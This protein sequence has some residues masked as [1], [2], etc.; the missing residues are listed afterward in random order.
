MEW[1]R[2]AFLLAL[3][4]ALW[5]C[6]GGSGSGFTSTDAG[7]GPTD[8]TSD[9]HRLIEAELVRHGPERRVPQPAEHIHLGQGVRPGRAEPA[10]SRGRLRPEVP[11]HTLAQRG[12]DGSRRMLVRRALSE[13][14]HRE[15]GHGAG[16]ELHSSRR[17]CGERGA[18]RPADRK[19][20]APRARQRGPVR[21]QPSAGH[22]VDPSADGH[23]GG[24]ERQ[25]PGHRGLHRERR[26]T[27]V[28]H[29]AHRP[30]A[31]RVRGGL[32]DGG[33]R[34]HLLGGPCAHVIRRGRRPQRHRAAGGQPHADGSGELGAA[35][36]D[37]A[38]ADAL[39]PGDAVVRR[40]RDL[41]R[42]PGGS[43]GRTS[44][45]AGARSR[46]TTITR[47]S[48]ALSARGRATR[49]LPTGA[50]TSRRGTTISSAL[51]APLRRSAP[52]S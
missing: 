4:G 9:V 38:A 48:A 37:P 19:V 1:G 8:A 46:R 40:G 22:G 50:Q 39:R 26:L 52:G 3:G 2:G 42:Q 44:T 7:H 12:P 36:G 35:V 5:G 45:R 29:A 33:A 6:H 32:R 23:R 11:A 25:H 18:A 15:R 13:R 20:A 47:G 41:Q 17:P 10:L 49:R 27:R 51:R 14:S 34:S 28:S 30:R 24:H 43:R 21:R 31:H 16:W